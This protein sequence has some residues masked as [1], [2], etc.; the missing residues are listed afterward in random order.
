MKTIVSICSARPNFVK[1]AA[2]H[3]ALAARPDDFKHVIVHT[4]QH[5]D[6][7]F[8]DIFF[9][10]LSI[11]L[12]DYNLGVHGGTREELIAATQAACEEVLPKIN[13]DLVLVYGDVNG[14]LGGAQAAKKCGCR[15]GHVE[16]GLRSFDPMMP[17][18]HNRIGID[19]IADL[20]FCSEQAGVDHLRSEK[21][22]GAI[23]LVGNTMIDTLIRMMPLIDGSS[24][25]IAVDGPFAIAT[26]HRPSNVDDADTLRS[27]LSFFSEVSR[28]IPLVL[29]AHHRLT[30]AIEKFRLEDAIDR[31][32]ILVPPL[33]YVSFLRMVKNAAF[34]LTD[35]GGIQEEA[36]Y[37]HKKCFTLR[38]NTERPS[39]VESG[40]NLLVDIANHEDRHAIL[41][42]AAHPIAP[43]VV[44]PAL[45][46]GKAGERIAGIL[47]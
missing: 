7:L 2:V 27:I 44:V 5:Y 43:N 21:V 28:H 16:A 22:A 42:F 32:V 9:E 46:D 26:L 25:P 38:R 19:A 40:S 37:L 12:P 30:A 8:S 31:H 13:S 11:P 20:L 6:P 34:V 3:H 39:T 17:E 4:G 41:D 29:P 35:S 47:A 1:V 24:V 33:A 45:W 18:E 23:H 15:V 14:A 10:Q 36:T